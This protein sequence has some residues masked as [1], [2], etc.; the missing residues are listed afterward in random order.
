MSNIKCAFLIKLQFDFKFKKDVYEKSMELANKPLPEQYH[1]RL[2][3]EQREVSDLLETFIEP[4]GVWCNK[5][6]VVEE[7]IHLHW[8]AIENLIFPKSRLTWMEY[9]FGPI[10]PLFRNPEINDFI[11][12]WH[13]QN[14]ETI[15][16]LFLSH[17]ELWSY[18]WMNYYWEVKKNPQDYDLDY[19]FPSLPPKLPKCL[20]HL[21]GCNNRSH[22]FCQECIL[23]SQNLRAL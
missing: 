14:R 5:I 17:N 23:W 12:Q 4:D 11:L 1:Q 2:L 18:C 19:E 6:L 7:N 21:R 10:F 15:I 3:Y 22:H 8:H 16:G 9:I 13:G 20:G